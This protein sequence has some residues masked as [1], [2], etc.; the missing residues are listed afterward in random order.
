MASSASATS[1][2]PS[3][4]HAVC[5]VSRNHE[6]FAPDLSVKSPRLTERASTWARSAWSASGSPEARVAHPP[7]VAR[8]SARLNDPSGSFTVR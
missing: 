1:T 2:M 5:L 7:D 8:S 3:G 4:R 6:L